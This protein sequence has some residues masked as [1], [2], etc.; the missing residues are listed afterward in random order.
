MR[1]HL[2]LG[3][4]QVSNET[5]HMEY[6]TKIEL[7]TKLRDELSQCSAFV[8]CT[9]SGMTVAEINELRGKFRA[10]GCHYR[11][12]KNST[13]RFAIK[14]TQHE[15]VGDLLKGVTALAYH[16][17][18]PG[19]PARVARDYA[20]GNDKF[21]VKGGISDGTAL[22]VSGVEALANL[23]GPNEIKSMLLSVINAPATKMVR[24]LNT[25]ATQVLN[26]IKAKA[27]AA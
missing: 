6:G 24:L 19:A 25:P 16:A 3:A 20:K 7:A 15:P 23:P 17:E 8:L 26:V 18:D 14:D 2:S 1:T 4:F 21:G 12:H 13:V 5:N 10:A 11:V 22:D 27:D 9:S